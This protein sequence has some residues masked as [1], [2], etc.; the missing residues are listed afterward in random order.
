MIRALNF[1]S[2]GHLITGLY[3]EGPN[4]IDAGYYW[5]VEKPPATVGDVMKRHRRKSPPIHETMF[6][7]LSV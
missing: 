2:F 3:R 5:K 1:A 7:A 6:T 4:D